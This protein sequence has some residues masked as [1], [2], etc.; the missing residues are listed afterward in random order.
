M[1]DY[2]VHLF[3]T[4]IASSHEILVLI[5]P[6]LNTTRKYCVFCRLQFKHLS[7]QRTYDESTCSQQNRK[8]STESCSQNLIKILEKNL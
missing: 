5:K 7:K 4:L 8:E 6:A 1:S 2:L 3:D